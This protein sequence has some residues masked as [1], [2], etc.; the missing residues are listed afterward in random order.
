[1]STKPRELDIDLNRMR[2]DKI[3]ELRGVLRDL[4]DIDAMERVLNGHTHRIAVQATVVANG[5]G[6][7]G[8]TSGHSSPQQLLDAADTAVERE[9]PSVPMGRKY[10][11]RPPSVNTA[12]VMEWIVDVLA[13]AGQPL[14]AG[15][16]T[17]GIKKK[18]PPP[19]C[20]DSTFS[21][22]LSLLR[23]EKRVIAQRKPGSAYPQY[24]LMDR[25]PKATEAK[26]KATPKRRLKRARTGV[27]L[28]NARGGYK[29]DPNGIAAGVLRMLA[30]H[31]EGLEIY[32]IS[33]LMEQ[34]GK[35]QW[36]D[37]Y[38]HNTQVS[39]TLKG[40]REKHRITTTEL[41]DGRRIH[42]AVRPAISVTKS[43]GE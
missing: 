26:P 38:T 28:G 17:A 10:K 18:Y 8:H 9:E 16:I 3:E 30:D 2:A 15:N 34:E 42:T 24:A 35:T 32:Q 7:N 1:M 14:Q 39:W 36:L 33:A 31:P 23:S 4:D 29:A 11:P 25:Q 6:K 37:G 27:T 21:R 40:H 22:A 19:Y 43:E 20:S 5:N 13:R 12:T 41:E